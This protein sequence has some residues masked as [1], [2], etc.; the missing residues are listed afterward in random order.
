MYTEVTYMQDIRKTGTIQC[1]FS[2]ELSQMSHG[3]A[4]AK[5][6]LAGFRRKLAY[7]QHKNKVYPI[8]F[9]MHISSLIVNNSRIH[10][11]RR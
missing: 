3:Q 7:S 8:Y 6:V 1:L 2:I 9:L 11:I 10:I 4:H 5:S